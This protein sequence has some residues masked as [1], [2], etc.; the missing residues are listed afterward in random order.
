[1]GWLLATILFVCFVL[2][3]V[4]SVLVVR[5]TLTPARMRLLQLVLVWLVPIIGPVIFLAVL[6]SDSTSGPQRDG[7]VDGVDAWGQ[8]DGLQP[9]SDACDCSDT[10]E[11]GGLGS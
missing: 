11:H 4:A 3:V 7:F 9:G 5:H 6:V 1:M 8:Q 2:N 10:T